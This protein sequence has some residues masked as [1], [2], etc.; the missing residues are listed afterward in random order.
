VALLAYIAT[1]VSFWE[2]LRNHGPTTLVM[3]T[4]VAAGFV[5]LARAFPARREPDAGS[6]TA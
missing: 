2:P 4:L 1:G 6:T 3:L 5:V